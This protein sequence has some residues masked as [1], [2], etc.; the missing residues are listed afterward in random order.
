MSY[1]DK[2]GCEFLVR[3]TKDYFDKNKPQL[4]T[5]VGRISAQI[6]V[7]SDKNPTILKFYPGDGENK[8]HTGQAEK[9]FDVDDNGYI[10]LKK[11]PEG[12]VGATVLINFQIYAYNGYTAGK[13]LYVHLRKQYKNTALSSRI[14]NIKYVYY[15]PVAAPYL[16][17]SGHFYYFLEENNGITLDVYSSDGKGTLGYGGGFDT[18]LALTTLI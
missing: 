17:F 2:A 6:N 11:A 15:I 9:Y 4:R 16:M 3:K 1:L 10:Y 5:Y 13:K 7:G 14:D 8:L 12:R 18:H